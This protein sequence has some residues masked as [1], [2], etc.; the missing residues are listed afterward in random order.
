MR[1]EFEVTPVDEIKQYHL[2]MKGDSVSWFRSSQAKIA[3][4]YAREAH[5][6]MIKGKPFKVIF[7]QDT[8]TILRSCES[9]KEGDEQC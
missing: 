3:A 2:T 9:A 4:L 8:E 7:E 6:R 1:I 5:K